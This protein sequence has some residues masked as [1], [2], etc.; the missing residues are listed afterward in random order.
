[1]NHKLV[2]L[3]VASAIA[4]SGCVT[5]VESDEL[6]AQKGRVND[7]ITGI[8]TAEQNRREAQQSMV[9]AVPTAYL[10][11]KKTPLSYQ[12]NLPSVF[13]KYSAFARPKDVDGFTIPQVGE[14]ITKSTGLRV[15]VR[16]DVFLAASSLIPGGGGGATM[17]SATGGNSGTTNPILM[18][19]P[20]T[21]GTANVSAT[22]ADSS[23][24]FDTR[25]DYD[26]TGSLTEYLNRIS[27]RTGI[28]WE[29]N[30]ADRELVLYRLIRKTFTLDTAPSAL[31]FSSSVSKGS[32]ASTGSS[33]SGGTSGGANGTTAGTSNTTLSMSSDAWT[34]IVN[35]LNKMRTK[36][37]VVEAN[38]ATRTITII[39]TR[40][41]VT[42][43]EKFIN[44]QNEILNRQVLLNIRLVTLALNRTNQMDVD[45]NAMLQKAN[46]W[47]LKSI[48]SSALTD[49]TAGSLTYTVLDPNSKYKDS[50]VML[51]LLREYG[52]IVNEYTQTVPIRNNRSVPVSDFSTFGYLASTSAA[53]SSTSTGGASVPGL[54]PGTVT[55]GTTIVL[56]PSILS[57]EKLSLLLSM[58]RSS[59][60][61]FKTITTGSGTTL[62]QIQLPAQSGIKVDTEVAM[63]NGRTLVLV[64][65]NKDD[66]SNTERNG[67]MSYGNALSSQKMV[68]VLMVTPQILGEK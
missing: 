37:G 67:A 38:P 28:Q 61:S 12:A 23:G 50:S 32:S 43:A 8:T 18:T 15:R 2:S 14:L 27:S 66:G 39:D 54:N 35:V 47:S 24:N 1:M 19:P 20:P 11:G 56:T 33:G 17:G 21:Y 45:L 40:D 65:M 36:A 55:S 68:Q 58:D 9:V 49:A 13:S 22:A 53:A 30:D 29:W 7:E 5:T 6:R 64:G 51:N 41:V 16:P 63:K 57:G 48:A 59:N 34:S 52:E 26:F 62:Q 3:A 10:S 31:T 4:L 44:I 60:P 42:D 46:G 25:V